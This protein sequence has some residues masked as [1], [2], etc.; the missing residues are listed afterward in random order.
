MVCVE[1]IVAMM[2]G[3]GIV[4]ALGLAG[5]AAGRYGKLKA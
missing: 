1:I 4:A 3:A 5:L 2:F